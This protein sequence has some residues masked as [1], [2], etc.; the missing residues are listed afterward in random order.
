MC[1]SPTALG[2]WRIGHLLGHIA[3]FARLYHHGMSSAFGRRVYG[4]PVS[5]VCQHEL[6]TCNLATSL[7]GHAVLHYLVHLGWD[8][9]HFDG[10]GLL[11]WSVVDEP[12]TRVDLWCTGLRV[13]GWDQA[14]AGARVCRNRLARTK[15]YSLR[16]NF[17]DLPTVSVWKRST[18]SRRAELTRPFLR[19]RA[20]NSSGVG[21][22]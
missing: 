10:H 14:K 1:C 4:R 19:S 9:K 20:W 18:K 21:H 8:R 7:Q 17:Q 22:T 16:E 3:G 6:L 5:A 15:A 11:R 2:R 12:Q 13:L